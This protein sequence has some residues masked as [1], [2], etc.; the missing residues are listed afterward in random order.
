MG[1]KLA[2]GA[3]SRFRGQ[4]GFLCFLKFYSLAAWRSLMI[5]RVCVRLAAWRLWG[6]SVSPN[7]L[8]YYLR[9]TTGVFGLSFVDGR[10]CTVIAKARTYVP[11]LLLGRAH[12]GVDLAPEIDGHAGRKR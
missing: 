5:S 12:N 9:H 6:S 4:S 7:V 10:Q 11:R 1:L 8:F 2:L 3:L